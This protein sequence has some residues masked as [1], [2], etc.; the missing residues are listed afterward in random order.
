MDAYKM[1]INK[2][3]GARGVVG[4]T[5]ASYADGHG[6]D[7]QP[8]HLQFFVS[9]SSPRA[10]DTDSLLSPMAQ[11]DPDTWTSANCYS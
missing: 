2:L 3:A 9:C 6:F 11:T 7:S 8:R 4:H 5:F 10:A 1:Y